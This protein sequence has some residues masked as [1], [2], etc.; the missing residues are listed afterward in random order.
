MPYYTMATVAMSC[1]ISRLMVLHEAPK[2]TH[3]NRLN[4]HFSCSDGLVFQK[5]RVSPRTVQCDD[6]GDSYGNEG[7]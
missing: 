4:M 7:G 3:G 6:Q 5:I 2:L 1:S